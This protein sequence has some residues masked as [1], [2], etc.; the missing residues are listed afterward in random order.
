[1]ARDQQEEDVQFYLDPDGDPT[2][3]QELQR[4]EERRLEREREGFI[5]LV[6]DG[7]LL[8]QQWEESSNEYSSS[9]YDSDEQLAIGPAFGRRFAR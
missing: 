4:E 5:P 3:Q 6:P 2:A 7:H 1:L 9:G 8:T